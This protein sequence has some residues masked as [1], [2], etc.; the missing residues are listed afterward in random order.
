MP[1]PLTVLLVVVGAILLV[2]AMPVR[3]TA[4]AHERRV[5]VRIRALLGLVEQ[6]LSAGPRKKEA[7][8]AKGRS[9]GIR[10]ARRFWAF[11]RSRGLLSGGRR[12]MERLW[13]A[14]HVRELVGAAR[15]GL[16][17]PAETGALWAVVGPV[18]G[19]VTSRFPDFAI[20]PSF[21]GEELDVEG[22]GSLVVVPLEIVGVTLAFALGPATLRAAV[23]AWRTR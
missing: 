17:D 16:E 5:R 1:W 12:F 4:I 2:L 3:L 11:V 14:L 21:G 6:E 18:S 22:R 19:F 9:G 13:R 10:S 8:E 15:I 7:P 23:A 20:A